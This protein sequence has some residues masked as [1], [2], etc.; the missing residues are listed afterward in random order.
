M[1]IVN[2]AKPTTSVAN[3][4]RPADGE[5]WASILTTWASETQA[6]LATSSFLDN[7][8]RVSSSMTNIAKP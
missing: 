1:T 3:L 6:W 8:A 2:T 5:T 7:A 4:A